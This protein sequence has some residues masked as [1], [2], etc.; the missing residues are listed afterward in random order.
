M[1]AICDVAASVVEVTANQP[2]QQGHIISLTCAAESWAALRA[3]VAGTH[4][5]SLYLPYYL[6][7]SRSLFFFIFYNRSLK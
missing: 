4:I 2:N 6:P 1:V 7:L 5:R 3:S